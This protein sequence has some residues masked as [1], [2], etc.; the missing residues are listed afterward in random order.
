MTNSVSKNLKVKMICRVEDKLRSDYG[1]LTLAELGGI[2][3][4]IK[5]S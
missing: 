5:I 4:N 1:S 2:K 3:I